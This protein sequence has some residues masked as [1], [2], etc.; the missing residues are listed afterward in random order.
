[1]DLG[2]IEETIGKHKGCA[3]VIHESMYVL[4]IASGFAHIALDFAPPM[5]A[6]KFF[7]LPKEPLATQIA[8]GQKSLFRV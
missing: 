5:L 7:L 2:S 3:Y 4:H 8:F 6:T 1:M